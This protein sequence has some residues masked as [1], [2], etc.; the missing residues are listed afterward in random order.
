[1]EIPD[2]VCEEVGILTL[3]TEG[4]SIKIARFMRLRALAWCWGFGFL[5]IL[6]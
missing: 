2:R 1:M 6:D 3:C 5:G 4:D